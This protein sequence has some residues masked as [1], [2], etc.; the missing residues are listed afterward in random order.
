MVKVKLYYILSVL[1]YFVGLLG[2]LIII[3][4][5]YGKNIFRVL[6]N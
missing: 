1:R 4:Y 6:N 3:Y 2:N 5:C